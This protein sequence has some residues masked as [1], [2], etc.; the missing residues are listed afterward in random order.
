MSGRR[1]AGCGSSASCRK[2]S[3]P[4][5]AVA[6]G[7]YHTRAHAISSDGSRV[8]WTAQP[9]EP[10]APVHARPRDGNDG[11]A[12]QGR[13]VS[14][15]RRARRAFQ[16]A[17]S[18]GS[19]VFFTDDQALVPGATVEPA[20]EITD[21]YVCEM[22]RDGRGTACALRDLTIPL[23]AGEHAAVQGSVLGSQRRRVERVRGRAGRARRQRKRGRRN[24]AVRAGQPV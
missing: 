22:V 24:G 9:G 11:P 17:S 8:I 23:H 16:T 6:L 10:G 3:G 2:A 12:G 1:G 7:Y 14:A 13:R 4:A 20:R 15:N 19:R 18:D 21:L 5:P